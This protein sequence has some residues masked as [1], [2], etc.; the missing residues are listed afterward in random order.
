MSQFVQSFL[1]LPIVKER[2]QV[3]NCIKIM[4]AART[5][6]IV[7]HEMNGRPKDCENQFDILFTQSSA[8]GEV[9]TLILA[10]GPEQQPYATFPE[11]IELVDR[12]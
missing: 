9:T 1:V 6:R 5:I 3:R 7:S 12:P 2:S 10:A 4:H 8:P 11:A